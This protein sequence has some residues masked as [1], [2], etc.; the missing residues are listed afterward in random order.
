MVE[1]EE[2]TKSSMTM[3]MALS[4]V[5]GAWFAFAIKNDNSVESDVARVENKEQMRDAVN[6]RQKYQLLSEQLDTLEALASADG[7]RSGYVA[8]VRA[9]VEGHER[10]ETK[11]TLVITNPLNG[12]VYR[13]SK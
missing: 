5:F 4:F 11:C 13:Y 9:V 2:M 3:V 7:Y 10:G 6:L 8:G 12:D 1:G